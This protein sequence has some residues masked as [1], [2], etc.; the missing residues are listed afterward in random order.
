MPQFPMMQVDAFTSQLLAGNPCA[1]VFDADSLSEAQMQAI[2]LE[3]NLSETSFVLQS[4]K[5]DFRVRYFTPANEIPLA[6]HPTV[7]TTH[8]LIEEGMIEL[9]GGSTTITLE[10]KA[11]IIPVE[12]VQD[13]GVTRITMTQNKPQF[14][15]TYA[16]EDVMPAMG[17]TVDDVLKGY[18]IQTVSTGTKHLM[19]PL[20]S[21]DALKRMTLNHR[22]YRDLRETGDFFGGPHLFCVEGVTEEGRTFARH[23]GL[24]PD[25]HEDPF[26]GSSTGSMSC[27]L[28]K[29]G[30]IDT[31]TFIAEQ[32][33]WMNRPG[34]AWVE[35]LG[36]RD[37]I[38]GVKVGGEAGDDS[39]GGIALVSIRNWSKVRYEVAIVTLS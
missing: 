23:P 24:P 35:I 36:E 38:T 27:Y 33:H 6:G 30:L 26:T 3:M 12:I 9:S 32:G 29:Y 17:L 8:A 21:L 16:P 28:W 19:I 11:G 4:D 7:A 5:A 1:I 22:L 15:R 10:M 13:G 34:K 37:N 31:P 18:P 20:N 39:G 2:A 25:T 14:M